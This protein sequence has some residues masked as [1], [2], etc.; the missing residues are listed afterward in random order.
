MATDYLERDDR[1]SCPPQ[2]ATL[3]K[4]RRIG[5]CWP[6]ATP[7]AGCPGPSCR[8]YE[9]LAYLRESGRRPTNDLSGPG[10]VFLFSFQFGFV[11]FEEALDRFPEAEQPLPLL[12]IEGDGHPLQP[13][14]ADG[15]FLADL[16]IKCAPLGAS[17]SRSLVAS[18]TVI[19]PALTFASTSSFF[20]RSFS[21]PGPAEYR[22]GWT[23]IE[24]ACERWKKPAASP[25][26]C[27]LILKVARSAC[28]AR[29]PT[30]DRLGCGMS[31][32]HHSL[33]VLSTRHYNSRWLSNFFGHERTVASIR[34]AARAVAFLQIVKGSRP[35]QVLEL[36]GERTVLGRHP[37]CEIVLDNAAVSRQHAQITNR[38]GHF[39]LRI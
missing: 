28:K 38:H 11:L 10:F 23:Q 21:L 22:V 33:T 39:F 9:A 17:S 32:S 20:T 4:R 8:S 5:A 37:S 12:D 26:Q 6:A 25:R 2:L 36:R 16:A 29:P 30:S 35:G 19:S 7:R 34:E 15:P 27:G 24:P 13:V 3:R 1:H 31:H 18:S 14:D